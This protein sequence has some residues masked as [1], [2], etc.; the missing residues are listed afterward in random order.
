M[1]RGNYVNNENVVIMYVCKIIIFCF[2][3]APSKMSLSFKIIISSAKA[4]Y[5]VC[6][7]PLEMR[8]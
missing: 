8:K 7:N 6:N 3:V 4:N 1:F 5:D 2:I